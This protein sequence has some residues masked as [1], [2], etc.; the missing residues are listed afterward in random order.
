MMDE[1]SKQYTAFTVG[2]LGYFECERRPFGL[3]NAPAT[4]QRLMQNGLGELNL[5]YCLI[6]LDDVIIY[7]KNE[8]EHLNRLRTIFERFRRDNFK[9]K[10]SKCNLFQKEITYL[11]H[12][13]SVEGIRPSK[14]GLKALAEFPEPTNYTQIRAFLGLVG[15]Y[16]QFIRNF[17]KI[18]WPLYAYLEGEGAM[19]KKEV[20]SLSLKAKEVFKWLKLELMKATVLSFAD[21][22]KPFLLETD[23]SKDGLGAVLLQKGDIGKY[24]PIAYGSKALSKSEKNYHSSKVEFLAL[25]WAVTEYFREYLQYSPEPFLIRTD[26]NPLTY[27]MMTPNLDATGHQWVGS[28]ANYNFKIE[29]LKGH[30]NSTTDVLCRMTEQL[31]DDDVKCLLDG[32]TIGAA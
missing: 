6:Y 32:I 13:V 14:A 22:S 27:V 28:L 12:D 30:D 4:F 25:K 8:E 16:H 26:N 18:A 29:Y 9:L 15:H 3:W 7:A 31:G 2:N 1:D 11:V 17:S 5:T 24:H 20:C 23:A 21:Y 10:P 19:K